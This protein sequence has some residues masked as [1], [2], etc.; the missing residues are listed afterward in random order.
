M[1]LRVILLVFLIPGL[2]TALD[3]DDERF[4]LR[5]IFELEW[6]SD[7][8][9][10]PNGSRIIY[11]RNFMDIMKDV[12]R[13]HLWIVSADGTDHRPLTTGN[14][15]D[16][17]P[18]WSPDGERLAY[19]SSSDGSTQLYMRWMDSGVTAISESEQ[20]YQRFS[21]ERSRAHSRSLARDRS[22]AEPAHGEGRPYLE[23]VRN[24]RRRDR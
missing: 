7:P 13:S 24:L 3:H 15:N 9:I 21:A 4:G 19:A 6:A 8:Q 1:K 2:A 16:F 5:D 11:V 14:G 20:Y 22:P 12:R 10:A 18:R 23:M 17:S